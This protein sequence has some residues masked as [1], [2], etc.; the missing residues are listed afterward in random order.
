MRE[1]GASPALPAGP[2]E[3]LVPPADTASPIERA[4]RQGVAA[5][6]RNADLE[7]RTRELRYREALDQRL[8]RLL[9]GLSV[10]GVS[11][12]W[13]VADVSLTLA[14]GL[15]TLFGRPFRLDPTIIIAF[16]T[17]STAT[18]IGLFLVFLRW[19][20]PSGPEKE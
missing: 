1:P 5:E 17:T 18:V 7:T 16:L 19:L 6:R 20:Y 11:V 12:L 15:G 14:Q 10:F 3:V 4:I 8:L 9:I 13:L 2:D